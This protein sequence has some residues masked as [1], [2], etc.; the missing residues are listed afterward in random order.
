MDTRDKP[1]ETTCHI[2]DIS[3]I[4]PATDEVD[5][6]DH[7]TPYAEDSVFKGATGP[8]HQRAMN[9]NNAFWVEK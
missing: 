1:L 7:M 8:V 4:A 6:H 2:D 5:G 3:F 9:K